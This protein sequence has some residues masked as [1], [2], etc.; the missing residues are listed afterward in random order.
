MS[1]ESWLEIVGHHKRL[2]TMQDLTPI[3]LICIPILT[4]Q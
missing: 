2:C 3:F 4:K 1:L